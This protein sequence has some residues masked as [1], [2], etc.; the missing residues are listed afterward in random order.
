M[1]AETI[2]MGNRKFVLDRKTLVFDDSNINNFLS[3]FASDYDH[4]HEGHALAQAY[5]D[6]VKEKYEVL[7]DAKFADYKTSGDTEKLASAKAAQ[8]T[9]VRDA[10][11]VMVEANYRVKRLY[12]WLRSMD[13]CYESAR[14]YCFNLRKEMDKIYGSSIRELSTKLNMD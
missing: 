4:Y 10:Y 3:N 6:R 12:G 1:E 9:E 5:H 2:I 14:E 13:K 8:D 11:L 7:R